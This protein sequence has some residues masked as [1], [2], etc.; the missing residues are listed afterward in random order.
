MIFVFGSN[1]KGIHGA[2]AAAFAHQYHDAV[3]GQGEGLQGTSYALPTCS[4]PG[5]PLDLK[6]IDHYID[7]FLSFA[8]ASQLQFQV[9]A[10]GCGIAGYK[11]QQIAPLFFKKELSD[12]VWLPAQFYRALFWEGYREGHGDLI[13]GGSR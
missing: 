3:W 8:S 2:G 5:V 11:P 4:E 6:A 10:I 1:L 12:N 7:Q 9:T 13:K